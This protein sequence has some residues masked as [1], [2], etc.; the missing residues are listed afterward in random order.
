MAFQNVVGNRL[1]QAALTTSYVTIYTTPILTRTFVK[2]IDLVNTTSGSL[3]FFISLVP[4]GT[5]AG[6]ANALF[7]GSTISANSTYQWTGTQILTPG[8]LISVKASGA[9]VTVTISG[10]EAT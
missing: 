5:A 9:G 2:N 4:K 1:A 7:F 3:T 10:G 6:A 8:D